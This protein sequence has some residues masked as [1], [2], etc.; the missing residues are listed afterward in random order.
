MVPDKSRLSLTSAPFYPFS[1]SL[2]AFYF[3]LIHLR[4]LHLEF[5]ASSCPL[6]LP[7][8]HVQGVSSVSNGLPFLTLCGRTEF[9]HFFKV[10]HEYC[11]LIQAYLDLSH[12]LF[13]SEL[14]FP[15]LFWFLFTSH[16]VLWLCMSYSLKT[17]EGWGEIV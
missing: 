7:L 6:I 10:S 12:L 13:L 14:H 11:F 3:F 8:F 16:P 1:L 15:H 4:H 9:Y 5:Q 17:P 2:Y